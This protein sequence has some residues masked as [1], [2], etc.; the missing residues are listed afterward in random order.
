MAKKPKTPP[1]PHRLELISRRENGRDV[2]IAMGLFDTAR[3]EVTQVFPLD[4]RSLPGI[5]PEDG[6][7]RLSTR[8]NEITQITLP[9]GQS[10]TGQ[11]I[12]QNLPGN[13]APWPQLNEFKHKAGLSITIFRANEKVHKYASHKKL[14]YAITDDATGQILRYIPE[15]QMR[16]MFAHMG[17][18]KMRAG[19]NNNLTSLQL[20]DGSNLSEKKFIDM[21]VGVERAPKPRNRSHYPVIA[22]AGIAAAGVAL[23]ASGANEQQSPQ[24]TLTSQTSPTA[25]FAAAAAHPEHSVQVIKRAPGTDPM[26]SYDDIQNEQL[27]HSVSRWFMQ[28]EFATLSA[29]LSENNE[30]RLQSA[31]PAEIETLRIQAEELQFKMQWPVDVARAVDDVWA[32]DEANMHRLGF[33]TPV[34]LLRHALATARIESFY[35]EQMGNADNDRVAGFYHFD[36]ATFPA[37]VAQYK[38][39]FGR[40]NAL[41]VDTDELLQ[42]RS[43]PYWSTMM[44]VEYIKATQLGRSSVPAQFYRRHVLGPGGENT[45]NSL[46]ADTVVDAHIGYTVAKQN[47]MTGKTASEVK[48]FLDNRFQ[49]GLNYVTNQGFTALPVQTTTAEF[50]ERQRTELT[51]R[52]RYQTTAAAPQTENARQ[53]S[54]TGARP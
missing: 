49:Q 51:L 48:F 5:V 6:A 11:E 19:R 28:G 54:Y 52:A 16:Q 22:A 46:A 26:A 40:P 29:L 47:G 53:V 20:A 4:A 27:R 17:V 31:D 42:L 35:G 34:D 38:R 24:V 1:P 33:K 37:M 12:I 10:G 39:N 9:D 15:S 25:A 36:E 14:G 50:N 44:L 7:Y 21:L 3:G 2:P 32:Q 41:R 43:D 13:G 8:L 23:M 18:V 45:L 30:K